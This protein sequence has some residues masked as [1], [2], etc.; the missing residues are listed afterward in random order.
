[1]NGSS[2]G[3]P[4]IQVKMI[5]FIVSDQNVI[6]AKGRNMLL[7]CFALWT[8]GKISRMAIDIIRAITPPSLFGMDRRIA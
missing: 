1:M 6:C 4:P 7:R 5:M 2:T 8:I 3:C